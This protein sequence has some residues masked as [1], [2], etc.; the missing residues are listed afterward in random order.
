MDNKGLG[1]MTGQERD[2][3]ESWG[4]VGSQV[5][6]DHEEKEKDNGRL[7]YKRQDDSWG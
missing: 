2:E 4:W 6:R 5:G 7:G 3:G 1:P